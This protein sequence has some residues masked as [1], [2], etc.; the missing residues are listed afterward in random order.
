MLN[1][2]SNE[3]WYKN[4]HK[5]LDSKPLCLLLTVPHDSLPEWKILT[6]MV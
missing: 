2:E 3:G 4:C 5:A 6:L 1:T